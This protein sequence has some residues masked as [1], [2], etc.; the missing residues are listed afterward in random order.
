MWTALQTL[1]VPAHLIQVIKSL[2]SGQKAC[3]RTEHGDSEE[4]EIGQGVRQGCILSPSLFNLY[5]EY[6][7]RQVLAGWTGGLSI[8]GRQLNNMRYADDTTLL[9][10][11]LAELRTLLQRV[12]TE[13]EAMGLRL[14]VA[15]TKFMVI[16]DVGE[17]QPLIV[18]G[19][20]VEKIQQF[21]FLGA[22]ISSKGGCSEEI[23]RRI[24]MAK[25]AM[26]KLNKIW[27]D[28]G[29]TKATKVRLVKALVFPIASHS[30]ET[31]TLTKADCR[32][33]DAFEMWCWRRMLRITWTMKRTNISILE[34]I[35]TK[36]CLL[37]FINSQALSY[38][39]HVARSDTNSLEKTV[40]QGL[41]EGSRR[42]GR[43]KSRYIDRIKK[44]TGKPLPVVYGLV[45]DRKK[46]R[47]IR[48]IT[49]C[50][51]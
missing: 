6:I 12:K 44:I 8:G 17:E 21:N 45:T 36:K 1:G 41:I 18:D 30:C 47:A 7:M 19:Q 37:D 27:A 24:A 43:P 11:S 39:G 16:G 42:P 33:I 40:M 35:G 50:Q 15:K 5:A 13:S 23:R 22:L 51:S 2:Y 28:R 48:G 4:F 32:K 38:F 26:Q 46:W 14:N 34:E 3:V 10:N 29:V 31:W 25:S 20:E 49:S 9:A